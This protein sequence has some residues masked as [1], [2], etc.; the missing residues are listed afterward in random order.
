MV[1]LASV[2]SVSSSHLTRT[3]WTGTSGGKDGRGEEKWHMSGESINYWAYGAQTAM[4]THTVAFLRCRSLLPSETIGVRTGLE[5][6]QWQWQQQPKSAQLTPTKI[7]FFCCTLAVLAVF[8]SVLHRT[9]AQFVSFSLRLVVFCTL[10]VYVCVLCLTTTQHQHQHQQHSG[11]LL[12]IYYLPSSSGFSLLGGFWSQKRKGRKSGSGGGGGGGDGEHN[13]FSC[14]KANLLQMKGKRAASAAA[15]ST[16]AAEVWRKKKKPCFKCS[17]FVKP[18]KNMC[19]FWNTSVACVG[20]RVVV[21]EILTERETRT[22]SLSEWCTESTELWSRLTHRL[23]NSIN[24]RRKTE[25]YRTSTVHNYCS[26]WMGHIRVT[27]RH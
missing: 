17:Y 16:T 14:S 7:L 3:G 1:L 26:L 22:N 6:K 2:P 5:Q 11:R 23:C 8:F 21:V 4:N 19:F 24:R 20:W 18:H 9:R 12:V 10:C 27:S 25:P 13:F 15:G